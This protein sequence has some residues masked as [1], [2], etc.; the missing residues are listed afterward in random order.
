MITP[1]LSPS[2]NHQAQ[3]RAVMEIMCYNCN[4]QIQPSIPYALLFEVMCIFLKSG[5]E[6]PNT[7]RA[8]QF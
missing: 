5:F 8:P 3:T 7:A 4:K 1:C 2:S 6:G